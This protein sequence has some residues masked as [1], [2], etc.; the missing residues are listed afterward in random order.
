MTV[1]TSGFLQSSGVNVTLAP[2]L[3]WPARVSSAGIE[4]AAGLNMAGSLQT[5][6]QLTG[7]YAV[8]FLYFS[9]L[10]AETCTFKL[11]IDGVVIWNATLTT[12]TALP[13]LGNIGGFAS[14]NNDLIVQFNQSFLLEVQTASDASIDLSYIARPIL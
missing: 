5:A 14:G 13:L 6:L 11:T 2:D 7:K 1:I 9:N 10:T 3:S 8:S 4:V 12:G